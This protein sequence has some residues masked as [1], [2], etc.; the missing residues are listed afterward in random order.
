M[1]SATA[2]TSARV[3]TSSIRIEEVTTRA[4]VVAVAERIKQSLR[5]PFNL[6]GISVNATAS[7]GIAFG[8]SAN[9]P[10]DLL[11]AAD[12]EMYRAKGTQDASW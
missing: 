5:S 12:L 11:H 2:T 8:S 3:V 4:E 9:V 1:R 10:E 7:L 6:E